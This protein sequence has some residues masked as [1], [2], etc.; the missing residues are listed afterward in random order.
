MSKARRCGCAIPTMTAAVVALTVPL[1]TGTYRLNKRHDK[2]YGCDARGLCR[3]MF[4]ERHQICEPAKPSFPTCQRT[5]QRAEPC[6]AHQI[7]THHF[8]CECA[9]DPGYCTTAATVPSGGGGGE[10]ALLQSVTPVGI[11]IS[12]S[13]KGGGGVLFPCSVA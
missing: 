3:L 5:C 8:L 11:K 13:K 2:A 10:L 6:G 12:Q 1:A 7:P 4:V 9:R